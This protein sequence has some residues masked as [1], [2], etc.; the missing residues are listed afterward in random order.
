MASD[1]NSPQCLQGMLG[2]VPSVLGA[3]Q[4][5][6]HRKT[7]TH[8]PFDPENGFLQLPCLSSNNDLTPSPKVLIAHET[9]ATSGIPQTQYRDAPGVNNCFV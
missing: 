4:T 3:C 9:E 2:P 8:M 7:R 6:T 5:H 1:N